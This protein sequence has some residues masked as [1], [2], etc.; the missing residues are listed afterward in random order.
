M[1]KGSSQDVALT[2]DELGIVKKMQGDLLKAEA[3]WRDSL[4]IKRQLKSSLGSTLLSLGNVKRKQGHFE[5]AEVYLKECLGLRGLKSCSA[6]VWF[7]TSQIEPWPEL[8]ACLGE[9]FN[10]FPQKLH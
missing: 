5:E 4:D 9:S 10:A 2:L 1:E 3:Y 8:G 6:G 7:L